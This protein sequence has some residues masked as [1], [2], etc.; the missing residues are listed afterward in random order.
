MEYAEIVQ[1]ISDNGYDVTADSLKSLIALAATH[2][3]HRH[4]GDS[5]AALR[6]V[7]DEFTKRVVHWNEHPYEDLDPCTVIQSGPLYA[8]SWAAATLLH[9]ID[10]P[11]EDMDSDR[12]EVPDLFLLG[13]CKA[14]NELSTK[15]LETVAL[16]E[17]SVRAEALLKDYEHMDKLL[18]EL[19]VA[20]L[21]EFATR[22]LSVMERIE[23][24][25]V[26]LREEQ[27]A[28]LDE[29]YEYK[30]DTEELKAKHEEAIRLKAILTAENDGLG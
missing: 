16:L 1:V 7:Q 28:R 29:R 9:R 14:N 17:K 15:V 12:T 19:G 2:R 11:E 26:M 22:K 5:V 21:N 8:Y 25:G 3:T 24:L 30:R 13:M 10:N 6:E 18:D 4:E 27:G 20:E 23:Q